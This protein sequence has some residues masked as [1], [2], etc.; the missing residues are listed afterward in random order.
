VLCSD[1]PFVSRRDRRFESSSLQRRVR[2]L[3]VPLVMTEASNQTALVIKARIGIIG[4]LL[5]RAL[6]RCPPMDPVP[7]ANGSRQAQDQ[8]QEPGGGN[9]YPPE[10]KWE[11]LRRSS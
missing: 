7:D 1:R 11:R 5:N 4:V 10:S 9:A 6:I 2:K 3:S 8:S